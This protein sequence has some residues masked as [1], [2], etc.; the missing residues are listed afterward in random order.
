MLLGILLCFLLP[1]LTECITISLPP[2]SNISINIKRGNN[3]PPAPC[4]ICRANNICKESNLEILPGGKVDYTFSCNTPER[5]FIME[6]T[7]KIDCNS[8]LCPLNITL[9]PSSLTGLNRTFLWHILASR[10]SGLIFSFSTPWLRQV[11]PSNTCPDLVNFNIGTSVHDSSINIGTFCRNGTVSRVKVQE[12]GVVALSLPWTETLIN[13]G[14]S[15]ANRSAIKRLGIVESTFQR[16][17]LV[18]LLSANYPGSFPHN[19][20]LTWKF[21]L[22]PAHA[23][24]VKFLNYT[25]PTCVK[26]EVE[27]QYGLPQSL[28]LKLSDKQPAN[29]LNNFNLSLKNCEV[30]RQISGQPGLA[31]NFSVTVQKSQGNTLYHLDFTKEKDLKVYIGKRKTVARGF[32][33]VCEIC[34]GPSDCNTE[35]VLEGGKYYKISFLCDNMKSLTV[36][37]EK[38]MTCWDL[39]TCNISNVPLTIP[40]S[41]VEFPL[42]LETYTWNLIAPEYI[43]TEIVSKSIYLQQ[44]VQDKPCNVTATGFT[45]DI[46]SC[47]GKGQFKIGT[48][49]PNGSIEKI[50]L[51]DN[52]TIVLTTPWDGNPN[53][54]L[55]HDLHVSFVSIIKEECIFTVSP[56]TG[57]TIYLQTPNWADGLPD[58]VAVSWSI[59]LPKKQSGKVKFSKDTMDIKCETG[60]AYVNIKEQK[61]NAQVVVRREDEQLPSLM[62]I[63]SPFWINISNCKPWNGT[64]KLKL[65]MSIT[66]SQVTPDLKTIL[67]A[68]SAAVAVVLALIIIVCCVKK[69]KKQKEDPV[70]IYN[71]RVNTEVPRRHA[72]FKKGRKNNESHVYAVIDDTMI[73]G[74]LLQEPTGLV[75]E[76]DVYQPFEGRM[77]EAP[78]VPPITYPNGS[79][80]EDTLEDPLA[81]SMRKNEIY[82]FTESI[83]R[84]PVENEDTSIPYIEESGSGTMLSA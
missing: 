66:F 23:A 49:C 48:F 20:Q 16:E 25:M 38:N 42:R 67:I 24:T 41:L 5:Y 36:T 78:P 15:I 44:N 73:Y 18:T 40:K 51:R 74:H 22:P 21:N 10:N 68:A 60:T 39:R 35:L 47:T 19:E 62:D 61:D 52:V 84:Q 72:V 9:Q 6:I 14:F 82:N 1:Y 64:N 37:A 58:H 26:N 71:S 80:I 50:Q 54:L 57:D 59:N 28:L 63:Y 8:G 30:D 53:K 2:T 43:S 76:V 7:R 81:Q 33:P 34:K 70:G 46:H 75:P 69:K 29:I 77:A 4:Y 3:T 56:K 65:L 17:S 13:P 79:T 32:V 45:Y 11:H 27:V 12:K 55:E 31:L 83:L